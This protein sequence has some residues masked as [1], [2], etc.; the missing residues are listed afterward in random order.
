VCTLL[1]NFHHLKIVYGFNPLTPMVLIHFPVDERVSL[2][3]N[4]KAQVVKTLNKSV[5]QQIEKRNRV[6]TTKAKRGCKHVV[7][8]PGDW[9]WV[10]MR[11]ERFLAHRKSKLQPRGDGSFQIIERINDNAYKVNLPGEYGVSATFNISNLTLM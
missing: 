10:H 11:K 3:G 9:V 5:R 6:Y 4:R 2:D 7:F 8:Q 1:L